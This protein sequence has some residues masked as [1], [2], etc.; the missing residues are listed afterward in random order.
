MFMRKYIWLGLTAVRTNLAYL[1]EA[2]TRVIFLGIILYIF[3][4][5]W[6]VTYAETKADQLD[7]L[8]LRQMLWYLSMTEAIVLSTPRVAQ[9]VDQ[10]V[11]TGAL[12]IQLI[13]PLSYPLYRLWVSLGERAVR[14]LLNAL[15]GSMIAWLFVGSIS[16]NPAGLAIFALA[17]PLAFVLDFLG[18]FLIGLG[19]FWLEDTSGLTI[20]Y[21]RLTMILGGMLIP[22]GLFPEALHPFLRSLP[23]ASI[24]GGPARLFVD[25]HWATFGG[26]VVRQGCFLLLFTLGVFFVYRAAARRIHANGG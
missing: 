3:L 20:I 2:A 24:V 23:F 12:S 25:P 7:G 16:F 17:L 6:Q 8:S 13:R 14:F 26:L 9:E 15:V 4:R 21:S 18:N 1:G 22:I 5:L 10:D 19:A 11:R